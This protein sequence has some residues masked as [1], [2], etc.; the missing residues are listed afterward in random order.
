MSFEKIQLTAPIIA[1][2]YKDNLVLTEDV[3]PPE[4]IVEPKMSKKNFLGN[5]QKNILVLVHDDEAVYIRE[6]WLLLLTNMLTACKLNIG[7]VAILNL[8][9]QHYSF[10]ELKSSLSPAYTIMFGVTTED[11]GL[12]FII[13]NYQIQH[14]NECTFVTAPSFQVLTANNDAAKIEK[15]KLWLCLK[16][17]FKV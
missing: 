9:H 3:V 1:D 6:E 16:Q 12:P 14:Y 15:S 7:D 4:K 5:N 17:I 11:I 2:L 8:C 13:P 10:T